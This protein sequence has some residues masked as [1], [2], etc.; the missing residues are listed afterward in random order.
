[1]IIEFN[2]SDGHTPVG[3][4]GNPEEISAEGDGGSDNKGTLRLDASCA[5]QYILYP[6]D[7]NLLNESRGNI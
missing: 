2:H 6:Q 3:G 5:P 4:S 7:I 1:M